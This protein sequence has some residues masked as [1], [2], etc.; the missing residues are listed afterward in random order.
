MRAR[1]KLKDAGAPLVG[2][3]LNQLPRNNG[4]GY[5]YYSTGSYGEGVYGAPPA[6]SS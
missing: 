3:V 6:G 2:F 1:D 5:Y 4:S